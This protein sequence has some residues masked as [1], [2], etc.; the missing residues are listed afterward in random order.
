MDRSIQHLKRTL[1][2]L[3]YALEAHRRSL[4]GLQS[5]L[6]EFEEALG[7]QEGQ[8]RPRGQQR[9][10]PSLLSIDDVRQELGMGKSWVYRSI[11]DG[12]IPSVK[13][14]HNI[15]VRRED[16]EE[17]PEKQRQRSQFETAS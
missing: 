4:E 11:K 9:S 13:L 1:E 15:K 6:P 8:Q 5:A 12:T 10:G 7:G 16:L 3:K 14:G 2:P 17:F